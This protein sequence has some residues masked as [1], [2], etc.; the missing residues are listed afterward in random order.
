MA[1]CR[2]VVA[3]S[4]PGNE[5]IGI[6]PAIDRLPHARLQS[7]EHR[8]RNRNRVFNHAGPELSVDPPVHRLS[9]ESGRPTAG[10][11]PA[12]RGKQGQDCCPVDQRFVGMRFCAF[13]LSHPE[14]GARNSPTSRSGRDRKRSDRRR[15]PRREIS[16][17]CR[18]VPPCCRPR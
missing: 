18:S 16:H 6:G 12:V 4:R 14:A 5:T 3:F 13:L 1:A 17:S 7:D 11:D 8:R 15:T 9:G 2:I 10:S